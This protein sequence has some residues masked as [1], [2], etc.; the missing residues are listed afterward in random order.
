MISLE[1]STKK[2]LPEKLTKKLKEKS[3]K[4]EEKK[5]PNLWEIDSED[6]KMLEKTRQL[7]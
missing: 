4:L 7:I 2:N 6:H 1:L 5:L 3:L